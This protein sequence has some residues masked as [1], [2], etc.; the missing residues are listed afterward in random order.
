MIRE[1]VSRKEVQQLIQSVQ[2]K[3]RAC[4]FE[5]INEKNEIHERLKIKKLKIHEQLP[6]TFNNQAGERVSSGTEG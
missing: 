6:G 4:S 3:C 1:C 2:P 5:K